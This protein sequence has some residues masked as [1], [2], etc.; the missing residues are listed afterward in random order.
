[1]TFD[2]SQV[3]PNYVRT[4]EVSVC[5]SEGLYLRLHK[6]IY[7]KDRDPQDDTIWIEM[8]TYRNSY[9]WRPLAEHLLRELGSKWSNPVEAEWPAPKGNDRPLPDSVSSCET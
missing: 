3:I 4:L 7:D 1:M 9:Q 5:D 8:R 2:T 6:R